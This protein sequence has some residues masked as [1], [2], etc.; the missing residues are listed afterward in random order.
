MQQRRPVHDL[1][2]TFVLTI[3]VKSVWQLVRIKHNTVFAPLPVPACGRPC[4]RVAFLLGA[5]TKFRAYRQRQ[6]FVHL[7]FDMIFIDG[8]KET[9]VCSQ[10]YRSVNAVFDAS[11]RMSPLTCNINYS[12]YSSRATS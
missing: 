5:R 4:A 3:I 11:H 1:Y 12:F 8:I 9:T 6:F 2:S 10:C 7:P